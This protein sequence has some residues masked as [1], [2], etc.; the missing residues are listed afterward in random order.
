MIFLNQKDSYNHFGHLVGRAESDGVVGL[1]AGGA[2]EESS[3]ARFVVSIDVGVGAG[4][5]EVAVVSNTAGWASS[6]GVVR[7]RAAVGRVS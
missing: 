6:G 4:V 5:L 2:G 7:A 3:A 1:L